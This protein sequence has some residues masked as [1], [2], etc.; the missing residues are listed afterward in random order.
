[1]NE[2]N[3]LSVVIPCYDE[4]ER[5]VTT[6]YTELTAQGA[7]VIVVDDGATMNLTFN[8]VSH[9]PNMGYGYAIKEGIKR[10]THPL[11]CTADGDGQH[12]V[13]DIQR[14]YKAFNLIESCDMVIGQRYNMEESSLRRFGRKFLN[15]IAAIISMHYLS[16]LNSG[17]RIFKRDL[18]VAYNSIL[19]DTFSFTTSL[20]M[21]MVTDNYKVVNF[22]IDVQPRTYGKSRVKLF[23]D[24][25]VTLY[26]ILWIGTALRTRKLR[27]WKRNI[28]GQ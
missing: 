26:Y 4:D 12:T 9:T 1:M 18:A 21:S 24:G 3:G 5:V 16:D 6:L 17:M 27:A 23:K 2:L 19:C 28:L 14:L 13:S 25:F 8:H 10:A 7:E 15:F 11:I 20:T 22:P